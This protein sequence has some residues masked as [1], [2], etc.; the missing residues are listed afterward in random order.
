M[1]RGGI[2]YFTLFLM[3]ISTVFISLI[4]MRQVVFQD[5]FTT[6]SKHEEIELNLKS[7]FLLYKQ[8]PEMLYL[9]E[10][11]SLDLFGDSSSIVRLSKKSWGIYDI[12][13][14]Y[15]SLKDKPIS[16][17]GLFGELINSNDPAL[18]MPDLG[19]NLSL[20]GS[21]K[22]IGTVH[23][24]SGIIRKGSI[25]G[26]PFIYDNVTEGVVK[27]ANKTLPK[28]DTIVAKKIDELFDNI[29]PEISLS[30]IESADNLPIENIFENP[31]ITCFDE[32]DA[33]ISNLAFKGKIIICAPGSILVDNSSS[34]EDV[35]LIARKIIIDEGFSGSFQAFALD[36]IIVGP[37]VALK[38]PTTLCI[39]AVDNYASS[40]RPV[41]SIGANTFINGCVI[42]NSPS[43]KSM[44]VV[45]ENSTITGQVYCDGDVDLK[46]KIYGS[47]YCTHFSFAIGR[48]TYVNHLL[49]AEI[50]MN[51]LPDG[52]CGFLVGEKPSTR[53]LI[54]WFD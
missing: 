4:L 35:I 47:L 31:E 21:T 20:S 54:R 51:K 11:V 26:Q 8:N 39:S 40:T 45:N 42:L 13:S 46:G 37:N 23:S 16:R 33:L 50:N 24:P 12:I 9:E 22:V 43:D 30:Q 5:A 28:F 36:S 25:E 7:A 3:L 49:N 48:S 10:S 53:G 41:I 18:Y 19:L 15:A 27:A 14:A 1:L 52:F 29:N 6:W 32:P 38:Y 44:L 17:S 34:L 2:L